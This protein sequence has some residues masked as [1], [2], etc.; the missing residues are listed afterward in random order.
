MKIFPSGSSRSNPDDSFSDGAIVCYENNA[1][2]VIGAILSNKKDK[3]RILN[4]KGSEVD[5]T[6][7]R[8]YPIPGKIPGYEK[9]SEKSAYLETLLNDATTKES[10]IDL[11]T[12]WESYEGA[13][14]EVSTKQVCE[15]FFGNNEALNHLA[16]RLALLGDKVYFKRKKDTFISRPTEAVNSL[17]ESQKAAQK[18][19]E[20]LE[21]LIQELSACLKDK[22]APLSSDSKIL[23]APLED[24]AAEATEGS[25][26][27]EA[28]NLLALLTERLKVAQNGRPEDRA[29]TLLIAVGH[30]TNRTNI[31]FF[32]H[33]P[34]IEFS[35]KV[36]QEARNLL[37][38]KIHLGER[39]DLRNTFTFTI[40]DTT[41]KDMDDALSV[42]R[43]ESGY[44]VGIH[45][46]DVASVIAEDSPLNEEAALRSTTIYCP[47]KTVHMFPSSLSQEKMSLREGVDT[48]CLSYIIEMTEEFE[49]KSFSIH[50]SVIC[51]AKKLSYEEVDQALLHPPTN[52]L[53]SKLHTLNECANKLEVDRID[54]GAVRVDRKEVAITV[55][56]NG[57]IHCGEYDEGS[58]ARSLVGEM[59]ILANRLSA[60][61]CE[62]NKIPCIYR[63]QPE[64]DVDPF[65][66]PQGVPEGPAY[67]YLIRSRLKR[68]T[69]SVEPAPHS[70]LGLKRYT[71]VT[72]PIRRYMDLIIQR[73]LLHYLKTGQIK[74]SAEDLTQIIFQSDSS[75][76]LARYL[77]QE[78]KRFWLMQYMLESTPRDAAILGTI[79]RTD[80]RNPLIALDNLGLTIMADLNRAVKSGDR[81]ALR[82]VTIKPQ[83]DYIKLEEAVTHS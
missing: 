39:L 68:S 32:K 65:S 51:S 34:R 27:K 50:P 6:A 48:L 63:A 23:L 53:E 14:V 36:S 30:I 28:R 37:Q 59:M 33:R 82:I 8:L 73:Q 75:L 35:E 83:R 58:P 70:S 46:S 74:F 10:E 2:L 12:I 38:N 41:T 9:T 20:A 13:E 77:S 44:K 15:L 69:I 80:L 78:S 17:L 7:D 24:L 72:S 76:T 5:L 52:E 47:E 60:E 62:N 18:R 21:K 54:N 43:L 55:D 81:V 31:S 29:L 25:S 79:V 45:I 56:S 49:I 26:T 66:N 4:H 3:Y 40:D 67:D 19:E 61:F 71:Q 57:V 64:P 16:T 42:E 1:N 11:A 22:N